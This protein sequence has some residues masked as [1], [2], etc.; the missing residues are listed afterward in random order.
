MEDSQR[1][2]KCVDRKGRRWNDYG[3]LALVH[4]P[5]LRLSLGEGAPGVCM[6]LSRFVVFDYREGHNRSRIAAAGSI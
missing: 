1:E 3:F 6:S 5:G 4:A 2:S